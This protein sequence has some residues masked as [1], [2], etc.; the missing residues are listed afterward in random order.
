[1]TR[2]I[3]TFSPSFLRYTAVDW[4]IDW[5]EQASGTSVAGYRNINMNRLPRWVGR[6]TL[7]LF[8]E[9]IAQW[10]AIR[11]AGR[12]LTGV[13]RLRMADYINNTLGVG[14][15]LPFSDD[16]LFDGGIGFEPDYA[17]RC[18]AGAAA[19]ATEIEVVMSSANDTLQV[20]Q[21]LSHD[22]WPFIVV[23]IEGNT[24][25]IEMPLRQAIP[26]GELIN[27]RGTGLF[28]MVTP[29]TGN[30]AY[31]ATLA[32]RPTLELQEWLR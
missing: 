6:P 23:A 19:G 14:E 28:E 24:L 9:Q 30:P 27:L 17:V 20:G 10:R 22:D 5:R 11:L 16:A 25:R 8:R 31:D 32:S 4:D 21:F 13:F 3:I 1:M 15:A 12:G 7:E 29:M 26:P 18:D 2:P